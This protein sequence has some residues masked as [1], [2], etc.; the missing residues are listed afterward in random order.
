LF[1]VSDW[2]PEVAEQEWKDI[3]EYSVRYFTDAFL[4]ILFW[5]SLI[6][7]RNIFAQK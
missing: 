3:V 7:D 4:A 1:H 2:I 5:N 6:P